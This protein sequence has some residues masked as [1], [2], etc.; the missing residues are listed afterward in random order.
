MNNLRG[1]NTGH[2]RTYYRNIHPALGRLEGFP[3]G[4]HVRRSEGGLG[5]SGACAEKAACAQWKAQGEGGR[6]GPGG[7]QDPAFVLGVG[8]KGL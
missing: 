8:L 5:S 6:E 7:G 1:E 4:P 3:P 2:L